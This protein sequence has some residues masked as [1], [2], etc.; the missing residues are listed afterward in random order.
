M[1]DVSI[2]VPV[3]NSAENI[4]ELVRQIDDAL[5]ATPHETILV[6]DGSRD[7]SW[8]EISRAT[9]RSPSTMGIDL[10]KNS[11]Q[12]NAIMAGLRMAR[13]TFVVIMDDDLQHSPYD[14]LQ[15]RSACES[16]EADV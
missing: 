3:F 10:R 5:S 14:I 15:L 4:E 2:V 16:P 7:R 6:N 9:L 12:D 1:I 8:E 11:G 13:G